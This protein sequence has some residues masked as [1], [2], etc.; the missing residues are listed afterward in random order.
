MVKLKQYIFQAICLFFA[1]LSGLFC[2]EPKARDEAESQRTALRVKNANRVEPWAKIEL[3]PVASGFKLPTDL[4]HPRDGSGRIFLLE[5]M[6]MIKIIK[7]GKVLND[8]FLD[9]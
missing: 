5:K 1:L 7:E 2:S 8:P 6:G 3:Q 4:I 9:I